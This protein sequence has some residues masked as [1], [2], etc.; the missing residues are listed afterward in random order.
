MPLYAVPLGQAGLADTVRDIAV[1]SIQGNDRVFVRNHFIVSGSIRVN[2][3][4][5]QPI[6]VQLLFENKNGEMSVVKMTQVTAKE[7]G[8][9]VP[10]RLSFAPPEIGTF[11]Y[12]VR[13][14]PQEKEL[15]ATNNEQS[16]FVRVI[17]GG[18]RVM[19][20]S[21]DR[22]FEQGPLRQS[23]AASEDINVQYVRLTGRGE[24]HL[25]KLIKDEPVNVFIF[26]DIDST[27]LTTKEMQLIADTV[28]SGAGLI[29]LGGLHAFGAG[30]YAQTPLADVCPV[31]LFKADRQ[32]P[33]TPIRA[34]IHWSADNPLPVIPTAEGLR[35]FVLRLG[36]DSAK[37]AERWKQLPGLLGANRFD[38]L[39]AGAT[40]LA[41]GANGE[42]LLVTQ[43]YGLGRVLAFAGDSTYRWRLAG[44]TEEH[45]LFWRQIVFWLAKMESGVNGDCWIVLDN[46]R[47]MLGDTAKFQVF[48]KTAEGDDV[49]DFKA[50]VTI[51]KPDN[52]TETVQVVNENGTPT[53]TFRNTNFSGNYVVTAKVTPPA[54]AEQREATARFLVYHRNLELDNPVAYPTLLS[55]IAAMTGGKSVPPENL[56]KLIE[57]LI[58]QSNDLVEKRETKQTLF[59]SWYVLTAF[60]LLLATEWFFRKR[61]G[62]V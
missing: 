51:L 37:N 5:D 9:L 16:G 38:R 54:D 22:N 32:M 15:V 25:E 14:V 43:M 29:M 53:G 49:K 60:I 36:R 24:N 57:E 30:G 55:S 58:K 48:L 28:K 12:T 52:N 39:K 23:L 56:G 18:L 13:V 44:F 46:D 59:D 8:Q 20:L 3:F 31:E 6:P 17:D 40:V 4:I 35:H 21:A 33:D 61:W 47:L 41:E 62:L 27:L 2:G 50:K 42:R 7:N 11:Q 26:G 34:D 19:C 1:D 45:K 10:Y